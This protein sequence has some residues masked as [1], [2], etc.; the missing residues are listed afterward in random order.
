M[1]MIQTNVLALTELTKLF[2][3]EMLERRF[4]RILNLGSTAS[5]V[6]GPLD[7]V[8]CATKAYVL[9]FSEALAEELKGT[10]V[11]VTTLC[12]GATQT[13]F[14]ERAQM[15]GVALFRGRLQSPAEVAWV[16]YRALMGRRSSVVVGLANKLM[17]FA[18]RF[19][20]RDLVARISMDLL[21]R[22]DAPPPVAL[23]HQPR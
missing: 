12:P 21:S 13:Q 6:P 23:R 11:T 7:A 9:S 4:G 20:P 14:A 10:G 2:L 19:A 1:Q 17:V 8:Y 3:P 16:G 5:F 15:T 18:L 22:A